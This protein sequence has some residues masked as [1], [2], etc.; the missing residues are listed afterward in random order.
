MLLLGN[1]LYEY[2]KKSDNDE[3][4]IV[5][6]RASSIV[7]TDNP[8]TYD[9]E[10]ISKITLTEPLTTVLLSSRSLST[11]DF[12]RG[13]TRYFSKVSPGNI[14]I[15]FYHHYRHYYY[16]LSL[17]L[18]KTVDD[19]MAEYRHKEQALVDLLEKKYNKQI[20]FE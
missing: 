9:M 16:H 17:E 2:R 10:M 3:S 12:Q 5:S 4:H 20:Y 18:V 14:F 1:I 11:F 19:L 8:I 13:L 6:P 7:Y 15:S